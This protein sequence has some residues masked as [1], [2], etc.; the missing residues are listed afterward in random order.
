[1]S[2]VPIARD[3]GGVGAGIVPLRADV[4]T[5]FAPPL[6]PSPCVFAW[7]PGTNPFGWAALGLF[8]ALIA[9]L[10]VVCRAMVPMHVTRSNGSGE[11]SGRP[12]RAWDFFFSFHPMPDVLCF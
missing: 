10:V 1:M 4:G 2:G 3:F 12:C 11:V 9:V 5:N 7:M 6:L 8:V